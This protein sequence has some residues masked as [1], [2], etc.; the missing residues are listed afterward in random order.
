[1]FVYHEKT[2]KIIV[3]QN[4]IKYFNEGKILSLITDAGT[5]LLSDPGRLLVN[6]SIENNIKLV[7][8]PGA[9]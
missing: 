5:P 3:M 6:H 1:M 8:I 2:K 7:P 4:I 9:S